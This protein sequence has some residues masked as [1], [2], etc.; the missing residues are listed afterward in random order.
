MG[1]VDELGF[2]SRP[3]NTLQ[4][5]SWTLTSSRP[6]AWFFSKT[7]HHVDRLLLRVTR[8]RTT[9]P[10]LLAGLPVI[11]LVTTG[12]RSGERRETPLVGVPVDGNLAVVGT[13]FGQRRTPAWWFN[14]E[15]HRDVEVTYRGASVDARARDANDDE[16]VEIWETARRIYAGYE[17][18]ARR[19]ERRPIHIA[20]LEPRSTR[21][22][23]A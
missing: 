1:L 17:A 2:E 6:G 8:G 10:G 13:N 21:S 7:I 14:L 18:Y 3:P 9:A 4:R 22:D 15:A 5:A 20:V 23:G 12:A 19:I 11:T 16:R